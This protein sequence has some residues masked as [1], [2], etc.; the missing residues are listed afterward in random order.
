[1][2]ESG[3]GF[4]RLHNFKPPLDIHPCFSVRMAVTEVKK[5]P[6]EY[7]ETMLNMLQNKIPLNKVSMLIR[8]GLTLL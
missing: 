8:V 7:E 1:M 4:K 3:T 5:E 6:V 2:N